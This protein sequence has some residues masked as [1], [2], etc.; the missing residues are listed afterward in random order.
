MPLVSRQVRDEFVNVLWANTHKHFNCI[1]DFGLVGLGVSELTLKFCTRISLGLTNAGYFS[2]VGL[3][4]EW[5][6]DTLTQRSN[7]AI[8]FITG[9]KTLEHLSLHLQVAPLYMD[10]GAPWWLRDVSC[11]KL[12]VDWFLTAALTSMVR[13][14]K[15]TLSGHV[16]HSTRRDWEAIFDDERKG[17]KHDMTEQMAHILSTPVAQL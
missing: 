2:L 7:T 5:D 11:Q 10:L 9:I 17:V 8:K 13:F 1:T 16:K 3:R 14:P 15:I 4:N 12:I 6:Q